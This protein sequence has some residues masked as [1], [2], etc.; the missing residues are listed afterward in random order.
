VRQGSKPAG[1]LRPAP[2]GCSWLIPQLGQEAGE[3]GARGAVV[4]RNQGHCLRRGQISG[5][6]RSIQQCPAQPGI[7]RNGCQEPSKAGGGAV[8]GHSAKFAQY[9][10]RVVHGLQWR[11]VRKREANAPRGTPGREQERGSG[12]VC[13]LDFRR[14]VGRCRTVGLLVVTPHHSAGTLA[15]RAA[16]AL[17]G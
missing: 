17:I 5:G 4:T 13:H 9:L 7:R 2:S 12:Q 16:G 1:I 3:V 10:H 15:G 14:Y 8:I 11:L 6:G